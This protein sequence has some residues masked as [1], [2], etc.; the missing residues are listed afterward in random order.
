MHLAGLNPLLSLCSPVRLAGLNPLLLFSRRSFPV[1]LFLIGYFRFLC[2]FME[3]LWNVLLPLGAFT[4]AL[5]GVFDCQCLC[6]FRLP[7]PFGLLSVLV[8]PALGE[9]GR[10]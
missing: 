7:F 1:V 4:L 6:R 9:L 5:L 3:F 2:A 10:G 8:L